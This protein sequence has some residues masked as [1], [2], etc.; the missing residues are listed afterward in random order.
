MGMIFQ[1]VYKLLVVSMLSL[2][3]FF[4]T[5]INSKLYENRIDF[6]GSSYIV[7]SPTLLGI[8]AET[9][10]FSSTAKNTFSGNKVTVKKK[11]N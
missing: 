7:G 3:F 1:T 4:T 8:S 5:Q 2:L 10:E 6:S 9:K 11:Q